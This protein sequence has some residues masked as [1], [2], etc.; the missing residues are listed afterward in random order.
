MTRILGIDPGLRKTGWGIIEERNG[1][2]CFVASGL[3]TPA[4]DLPLANRLHALYQGVTEVVTAYTPDST[5]IEE[6]FVNKNPLSSLKLGHARG[7]LMLSLSIAGLSPS[8][9]PATL[10]KKSIS[11]AGRAEKGQVQRMI[12]YLLPAAGIK[13]EDEADALAVAICHLHHRQWA[14]V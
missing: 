5:A 3:I 14:L 12:Q 6:T 4:A 9:Y 1:K 8:E 2:L 11:G 10:V 13:S 7:A